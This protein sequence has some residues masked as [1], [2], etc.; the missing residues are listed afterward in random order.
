MGLTPFYY[1]HHCPFISTCSVIWQ[2]TSRLSLR[3][4][5]IWP[6]STPRLHVQPLRVGILAG[7]A[8]NR[9]FLAPA[10]EI[11]NGQA[12]HQLYQALPCPG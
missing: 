5:Y 2:F 8:L 7:R 1:P 6:A 3:H 11:E 4:A 9:G 12:S 10:N